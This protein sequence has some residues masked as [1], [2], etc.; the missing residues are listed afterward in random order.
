MNSGHH[1]MGNKNGTTNAG[2]HKMGNG[3][4]HEGH[5]MNGRHKKIGSIKAR[6]K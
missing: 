3:T 5:K 4:A 2:H 6:Q 1:K